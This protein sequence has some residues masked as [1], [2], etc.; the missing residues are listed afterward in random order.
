L[1]ERVI[2]TGGSGFI[3]GALC[4]QLSRNGYEVI[5]LSRGPR[6]RGVDPAIRTVRWDGKSPE[7]WLHYAE[8]ARAIVNLAG[9]SIAAGRWTRSRRERI[10]QSRLDAGSAVVRAVSESHIRPRLLVQ[11]SAI[12]F[13]GNR[14]DEELDEGSAPGKGFLADVTRRWEESTRAVESMGVRR[15]LVRLAVVLGEGGMLARLRIPF[16]LFLGGHPGSG[17]QWVSWIHIRDAVRA[18]V[19]LIGTKSGAGV[20]TLSSPLPLPAREFYRQLGIS[21]NRPSWL[22]MPACALRL[23]FGQMAD[24]LLLASQ[25]VLPRRLEDL[26]FEFM[27]PDAESA[28]SDIAARG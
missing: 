22:P 5:V 23:A 18:I 7:G 1:K 26:G 20:F 17:M 14:G 16:L 28:F 25:R 21:W 10:L 3:G 27:F 8:G 2:V 12:G 13:Y 4:A 15:A 11:A 9:E 19:F 24:E 6:G